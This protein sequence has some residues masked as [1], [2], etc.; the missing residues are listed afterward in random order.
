MRVVNALSLSLLLLS[1]GCANL[2]SLD[3][4][5]EIGWILPDAE[6]GGVIEFPDTVQRA[7]PTTGIVTTRGS[8]SCT[9][10]AGE[11]VTGDG[12]EVRITPY[13]RMAPPGRGCTRDLAAFPRSVELRFMV[14]GEASIRVV[15]RASPVSRETVEVVHK[16]IVLP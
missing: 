12:I 8:S 10:P 13:D 9:R 7:V 6:L 14:A 3:W 5:R 4:S 1:S 11:D 15:G 16:V 2:V